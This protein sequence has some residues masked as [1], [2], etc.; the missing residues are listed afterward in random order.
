MNLVVGATGNLGGTICRR[1]LGRGDPVRA[2]LRQSSDYRGLE[3]AGA[4]IA[5]GDLK[6]P[7]SLEE[8]CGGTDRLIATATA[9]ARGGADTIESVD[10]AGYASLIRAAEAANVG[11]FIFVSA[12]GFTPD[13]SLS[14]ARAKAATEEALRTSSLDETILKPSLF[15]EAWFGLVLGM[16]VKA[17]SQVRVVGDP[18]KPYGFVATENVA[19]LAIAVLEHPQA[20]RAEIPLSA[21]AVSFRQII[22]WIEEA[23]GRSIEIEAIEPGQEVRGLP[24][25]VSELWAWAASGQVEGIET[26]DVA[27]KF[28]IELVT[29]RQFIEAAFSTPEQAATAP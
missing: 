7:A 2:L 5:F 26:P 16:Q 13:S 12:H 25:I 23:I 1:L 27:D 24:P 10:R 15:M 8:A 17:G 18:D 28:G 4:K 9:A 3:A 21:A 29:P 6:D 14:L 19:D 11:Q 22:E 20:Q